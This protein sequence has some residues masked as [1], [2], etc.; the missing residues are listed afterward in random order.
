ME[1]KMQWAK[2]ILWQWL[3]SDK[4][5]YFNSKAKCRLLKLPTVPWYWIRLTGICENEK[6]SNKQ[7]D[8][9]EQ[10]KWPRSGHQWT[11]FQDYNGQNWQKPCSLEK[12]NLGKNKHFRKNMG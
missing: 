8:V 10:P 6:L 12:H 9:Q 4:L 2:I 11:S 1:K 5:R 3:H 7:R